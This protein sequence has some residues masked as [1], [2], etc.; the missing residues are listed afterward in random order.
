M[1]GTSLWSP[2]CSGIRPAAPSTSRRTTCEPPAGRAGLSRRCIS[3]EGSRVRLVL[4]RHGQTTANFNLELDTAE[5]GAP[6]TPLG[7]EQAA[8]VADVLSPCL[9]YTSPSPRD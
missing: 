6:L 9:L 2:A 1:A 3:S 8:A 7:H 5:P 4:V